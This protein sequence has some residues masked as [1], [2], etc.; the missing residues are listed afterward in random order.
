LQDSSPTKEQQEYL[1]ILSKS[2]NILKLLISDILDFSKI[3]AGEIDIK[4]KEF[5]IWQLIE[6]LHKTTELKVENKYILV[7]YEIDSR[8]NHFVLGDELLLNQILINLLGNASKFTNEGEIGIIVKLLD[9][10]EDKLDL[11]FQVFDTGIGI[12]K[13]K[14]KLIFENFKQIDDNKS[15]QQ[16]FDGTGLGLAITKKL[17]EIQGGNIT[18]ESAI[19]QR[20]VFTF[21]LSYQKYGEIIFGSSKDNELSLST[22]FGDVQLL[23][24]EDNYMNQKYISSLLKKWNLNFEFAS[25]GLMALELAF[26]KPYDLIFMDISMPN[27][28][29]YDTTNALRKIENPNQDTP[30][31]ALSALAFINEKKKALEIGMTDFLGKPFTPRDL[32]TIL[33]TYIETISLEEETIINEIIIPS[34]LDATHIEALYEDDYEYAAEMFNIFMEHTKVEFEKILPF[35]EQKKFEKVKDIAHKLKPNFSMVGLLLLRD[36][37]SD[38]EVAATEE[39]EQ[40]IL[41]LHQYIK[42]ELNRA[43]PIIEQT[44][45]KFS[46]TESEV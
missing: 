15:T 25:D 21:N 10:N 5:D 28:N 36:K 46:Q 4:I 17:V 35:I 11:E 37:V 20:T 32:L 16:K 29:G 41:I 13:A 33:N 24:V 8:I 12:P 1:S 38:L 7:T 27:M 2:S 14:Q 43:L 31:I 6:N 40:Q 22:R 39:N 34:P 9:E 44:A 18:V 30:I 19:N 45:K 3:Q 42:Q 23:V 26:I